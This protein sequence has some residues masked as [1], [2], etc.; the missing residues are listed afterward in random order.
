MFDKMTCCEQ[1][2][3]QIANGLVRYD[4]RYD[5]Y[6]IIVRPGEVEVLQKIDYCPWSG[7][8][9]PEG[10]RN[11]WFDELEAQGIDPMTDP[12]PI[13]Y[14]TDAWRTRPR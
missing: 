14:Q 3:V 8:K 13:E 5:E 6:S 12:I 1:M 10:R 4:E 11:Q 2:R 7:D 9:L